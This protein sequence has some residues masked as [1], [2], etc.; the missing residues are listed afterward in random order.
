V[1]CIPK[2]VNFNVM[3]FGYILVMKLNIRILNLC[4]TSRRIPL[5]LSAFKYKN[6]NII[7]KKKKRKE[8]QEIFIHLSLLD[9]CI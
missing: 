9:F 5:L 8:R 2:Y 4:G 7:N 6:K 3:I 1:T